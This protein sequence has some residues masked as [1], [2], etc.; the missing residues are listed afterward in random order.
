MPRGWKT[1][2]AQLL[3]DGY[4]YECLESGNRVTQIM[5]AIDGLAVAVKKDGA[6]H[7][8]INTTRGLTLAQLRWIFSDWSDAE[9]ENDGVSTASCVPNMD[10]NA[11]KEWSDLDARCEETPINPYGAGDQ[12]ATRFLRGDGPG[13]LRGDRV[14]L[15][16]RRR[17]LA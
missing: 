11:V 4:T 6:A 7:T 10:D 2:E 15:G 16:L 12:S 13:R 1:S 8:C 5:V 14:F 9:L 3:D 17:R